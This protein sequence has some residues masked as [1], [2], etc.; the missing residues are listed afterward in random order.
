M[1]GMQVQRHAPIREQVAN[2]LRDAIVEQRL[3]P[4]QLLV[5]RELCAMT[6]ASRPSV[7]EAL[8]Q[9]QAEGLIESQ[10]GK[11]TF[12]TAISTEVA[13]QVY[14]V[15]ASLEGLAARLFAENATEEDR[16]AFREAVEELSRETDNGADAAT[17][18][19][20]KS[21]AYEVLFRGCGNPV[22]HQTVATL[23]HRVTRLRALTLG[24]QGRAAK[25]AEE[26]RAIAKAVDARDGQAAELAAATHVERAAEA[27]LSIAETPSQD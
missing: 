12:V 26:V 4:G 15:R 3:T 22:L 11:G 25:S 13:S 5:E 18:L 20:A 27:M 21:R 24:Q 14:Q 23:Q 16:A 2:I 17:L 19:K 7:R 6:G 10:N 9:L 1:T 8:R